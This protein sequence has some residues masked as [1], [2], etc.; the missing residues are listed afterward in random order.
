MD[1][2][3]SPIIICGAAR[4]GTTFIW[5]LLN[6]HPDIVLSDEFFIYKT[7]SMMKWFDE[8][9]EAFGSLTAR[10]D[11]KPRKAAIMRS[12]WYYTS[13]PARAEAGLISRR[14]GN[15][16]PGS[17]LYIDF[18]EDVFEQWPPQYIYCMRNPKNVFLSV[19]NMAWGKRV[20]IRGQVKRYIE[21]VRAMEAFK[22]RVPERMLIF[23]VDRVASEL[24]SRVSVVREI[25]DYVGEELADEMT[26]FIQ[27]WR[28]VL[29]TERVRRKEP[30]NI[31]S[32]LPEKDIQYL[33]NHAGILRIA[34]AYGYSDLN[35]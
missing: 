5:Q 4:S 16:T 26:P 9:R 10:G 30:E 27:S 29:S 32:S 2:R 35:V 17:E 33:K 20:H 21:S 28:K 6:E 19:R 12:L 25:L 18:Y 15:K 3:N 34:H 13:Q 22:K 1:K 14:W 23:Q 7:P 24:E 8:M 31:L 11:W